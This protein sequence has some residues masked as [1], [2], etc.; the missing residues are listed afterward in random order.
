MGV[1]TGT[2]ANGNNTDRTK[3]LEIWANWKF[4]PEGST[5]L[6]SNKKMIQNNLFI[7]MKQTHRFQNQSYGYHVWNCWREFVGWK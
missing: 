7:Q 2:Y 6:E 4:Q 1:M 5:K 3:R